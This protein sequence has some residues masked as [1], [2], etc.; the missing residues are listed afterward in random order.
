[1]DAW[2]IGLRNAT[3]TSIKIFLWR[4]LYPSETWRPGLIDECMVFV[5]VLEADSGAE[6]IRQAAV[7]VLSALAKMNAPQFGETVCVE[8]E[9]WQA[10]ESIR[11]E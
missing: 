8:E 10:I 3:A 7:E 4:E 6:T 5:T 11:G 1:M 9:F 2:K